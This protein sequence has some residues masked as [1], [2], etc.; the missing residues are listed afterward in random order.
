MTRL[1]QLETAR[2]NLML[3][4]NQIE[5]AI[6]EEMAAAPQPAGSCQAHPGAPVRVISSF[7]GS[8]TRLCSACGETLA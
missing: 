8:E 6:S 1:Q 2:A 5:C 7:S 3:A 4:L